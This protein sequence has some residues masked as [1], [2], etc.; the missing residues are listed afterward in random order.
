M[1]RPAVLAWG[2]PMLILA[3]PCLVG[4]G[5]ATKAAP[6]EILLREGSR[7]RV[8]DLSPLRNTLQV[9]TA[10]EQ[11]VQT[12]LSVP[13]SV[14]ADPAEL[15]KILPP[16][17]GR[18]VQLHVHLGD[19]VKQGQPLLTME[20]ADLAQA[21]AD[22]QKALAQYQQ[23]KRTVDRVR[24][25][26]RHDIASRREVDQAE[27]D[28]ASIESEWRRA[29][30]HILQL[31]ANP[32]GTQASH[33]LTIRAPI[34]A[35]VADL[36]AGTGGYWND[37]NAPLMVLANLTH[38]WFTAS[39]QEKDIAGIFMGQEVSAE[40]A[41]F[42]GETFHSKVAFVGEMLDPDTRTVKVRM[43]FDNAAHRL[44]PAMFATVTFQARPHK[45]I[46]VPLAAVIQG[47]EGSKVFVEVAPWTFEAVAVKP[48][49]QVG[50]QTEILEG[51]KTGQ[52][53]V[54]REGVILND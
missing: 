45:G 48:G 25:L 13:A 14:E 9:A 50:G 41:S 23:A 53:F 2:L 30:A 24:E 38:V 32:E 19:W 44:L 43:V 21:Y 26:G 46:L 5:H 12:A 1:P 11:V 3:L 4:C 40:L 18:I 6:A 33:L 10:Q 34:A 16:L 17:S 7:I 39:V 28:F 15:V 51:L 35:R 42:P 47:Q 52:R 29:R 31:G 36:A 37:L 8:P 54:A 27:T 20:S 49:A 22:L